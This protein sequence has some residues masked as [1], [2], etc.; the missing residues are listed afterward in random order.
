METTRIF[1]IAIIGIV[2]ATT[3]FVAGTGALSVTL[4]RI[5]GGP[6][7]ATAT[8]SSDTGG[9]DYGNGDDSTPSTMPSTAANATT[10]ETSATNTTVGPA[11]STNK[12]FYI[13][14]D[15]VDDD[16]DNADDIEIF[17]L[18][19][20]VVNRGDS[21]TI[22]FFNLGEQDIDDAPE[23]RHSFTIGAPYNIDVDLAGG[24]NQV[25][26]LTADEEGIFQYYSKHDLP[27]MTG[28]LVVLPEQQDAAADGTNLTSQ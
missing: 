14:D 19:T 4:S 12:T 18:Q 26:T 21:V 20:I 25:I 2:L 11:L 9:G 27:Q 28:Q 10:T 5:P 17:S 23:Q 8:I 3:A 7:L 16:L 1:A 15:E 22:H 24:E 6:Q 13:S